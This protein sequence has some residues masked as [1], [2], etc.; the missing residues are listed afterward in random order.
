MPRRG[1][2]DFLQWCEKIFAVVRQIFCSGG[3]NFLQWC[4]KMREVSG[5]GACARRKAAAG[6]ADFCGFG[7]LG[8]DLKKDE[9]STTNLEPN[10]V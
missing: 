1:A 4:G 2:A 5:V 6:R 3:R 7:G 9:I 10:M 8:K